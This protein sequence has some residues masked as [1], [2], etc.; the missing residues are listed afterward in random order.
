MSVSVCLFVDQFLF[1][2]VLCVAYV[3]CIFSYSVHC[4]FCC[5]VCC[6][7]E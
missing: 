1:V 5:V 3:V 2:F 4:V 6:F 7:C